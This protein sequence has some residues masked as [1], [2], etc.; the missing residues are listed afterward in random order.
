MPNSVLESYA[1]EKAVIASRLGPLVDMVI[2]NQT[3]LSFTAADHNDLKSKI[4]YCYENRPDVIR[5]GKNG[6]QKLLMEYSE[7]FHY[8]KLIRLFKSV[9]NGNNCGDN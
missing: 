4:R 9:T 6:K 2:D 8:N 5:F 3:G 1:Y 7:K